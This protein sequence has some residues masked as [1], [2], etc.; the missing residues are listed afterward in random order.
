[1]RKRNLLYASIA[2]I[3]AVLLTNVNVDAREN[4]DIN[5]NSSNPINLETYIDDLFS[6]MDDEDIVF[7]VNN[8]GYLYSTKIDNNQ[9][10]D[11][12]LRLNKGVKLKK[13][14]V[15]EAKEDVKND[16]IDDYLSGRIE[17]T[18]NSVIKD[19]NND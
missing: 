17:L 14:T 7:K 6:E 9:L 11:D 10:K 19:V 4:T 5:Q 2:L 18:E 15:L 8:G 12:F 13:M 3:C 1:M 16:L